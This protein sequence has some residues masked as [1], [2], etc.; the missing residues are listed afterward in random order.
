[1]SYSSLYGIKADYTGEILC[2]YENSWW[3]S[4]VV[5]S[6]LSDKTLPKVM[7]YIQS[8]IGMHGADVWKKINTKMN[9]ST[10]TSDR[11]C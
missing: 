7:G 5:W 9:N 2:E 11:I 10:N 4:P 3:F 1:M 6:V 8:V